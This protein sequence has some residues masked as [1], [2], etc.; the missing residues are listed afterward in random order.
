M[1]APSLVEA[2]RA[3]FNTNATKPVAFRLEQLERLRTVLR[4]NE[5][6]I[7]AALHA[8][9]GKSAFDSFVSE[10]VLVYDELKVAIKQLAGWTRP[11]RVPTNLLNWPARSSVRPEPLGVVLVIGAWNYPIQL[12]LAPVVAALAAGN[13]VV[14]KPSELCAATS[15]IVAALVKQHFDPR[16]LTVVE[17]GIPETTALLEQKFDKIFFTGSTTVGRIVYQA[18]AR[19]LTP[20]TLEL[21]GKSPAIFTPGCELDTSIRRLVWAKF[22]NAGQTCIAPDY[23]LVH[24]S[25]EAEFLRQVKAEIVRANLSLASGTY[26]QI[27]DERSVT[28]IASLIDPAKVVL[29]G[30]VDIPARTIAPTVMADVRFGDKVMSEEIFGPVLPV[31]RYTDLDAAIAEI[32]SRSKPLALYLFTRDA[33]VRE[34]VLR[35]VSFGG[36][37]VNDAVM[38]IANG[39]LPFGGVGESGLGSYHGEAGFRTFSHYKSILDKPTW[40]EPSLKYFPH[41]PRK[42]ALL[43]WLVG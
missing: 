31:I 19:H 30:E 10:F 9:Y 3:F 1:N 14:L 34:K 26:V 4:D 33:A 35:E 29:G 32:K 16:V 39:R 7:C 24:E 18:A 28:R 17:G 11:R 36:G 12:S 27:I 37:C 20:V 21:G 42:L 15:R 38:H 2:Q 13:T 40:F 25:L 6:A 22:L 5:A 43:R 23:V 8:D 41:T